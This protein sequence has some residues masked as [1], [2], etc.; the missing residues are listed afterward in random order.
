MKNIKE[1]IILNNFDIE[2]KIERIS[3]QILEN[4]S[5]EKKI[6]FFGISDNGILIAKKIINLINK[7]SNLDLEF[8]KASIK[9]SEKVSSIEY[10]KK[11]DINNIS[12]LIVDDISQSG[13]TLQFA[14]SDLFKYN[15]KKIQT[16]V[17]VNRDQTLFPVKIDY[18]GISLSTS[19]NEH[20]S[21]VKD[22]ND[23]VT[24]YLS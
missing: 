23:K 22:K 14:I 13:K 2:K 8:F 3:L 24:I 5:N 1:N 16:I 4:N 17:L 11:F 19:V 21:F 12:I 15:P 18:S 20:V 6:I 7:N 9:K 10:D